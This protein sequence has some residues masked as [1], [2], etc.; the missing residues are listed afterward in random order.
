MPAPTACGSASRPARPCPRISASAGA[1]SQA[2]TCS[3]ASARPRCST[4]FCRTAP[5]IFVMARPARPVPGYEARIVD[6]HGS[7]VGDGEIGELIVRGPS[8]GE[9]YWNQ[10]EKSRRTFVGEWT[11]TGDKYRRDAEGYY[12]LL[13]AHRRHVQ[14]FRHVG[15]AL[16]R[17]GGACLARSRAGSRR[18]RQG[19]RR[20]A[21]QAEGL[22]RAA[23]RLQGRRRPARD[24]QA[25]RQ[26]QSRPVEIP[27]LDRSA[28]CSFR[29]RPPARSSASSCA[30]KTRARGGNNI[31]SFAH[32]PLSISRSFPRKRESRAQ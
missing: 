5:G 7:D 3:T 4:P 17:R 23:Q 13:R 29:A 9:G 32:R 2:S 16:R 10:R 27:A 21:D 1:R 18:H 28:R 19:R 11:H 24:A 12:L 26:G 6:E 20:R 15:V 8:A 25:P 14:G 22:H 31:R 30:R